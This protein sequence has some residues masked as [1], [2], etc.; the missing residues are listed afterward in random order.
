[1]VAGLDEFHGLAAA[2]HFGAPVAQPSEIPCRVEAGAFILPDELLNGVLSVARDGWKELL[3]NGEDASAR[4]VR[5]AVV[6]HADFARTGSVALNDEWRGGLL[7]VGRGLLRRSDE[8]HADAALAHIRLQDERIV[9]V[10]LATQ[11]FEQGESS[12]LIFAPAL[13]WNCGPMR[14]ACA[15]RIRP[16]WLN[17]R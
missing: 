11:L 9:D 14:V 12:V 2:Q 7:Q 6:E 5:E 8:L 13:A 4:L 1:M 3:G 17:V 16:R 10:M 15:M